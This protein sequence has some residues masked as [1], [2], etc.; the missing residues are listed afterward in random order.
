MYL[1]LFDVDGTL[2]D[3]QNIIFE[4]MRRAFEGEGRPIP[5][6]QAV[7]AII[8]MSLPVALA[9]LS[10]GDP[11]DA[12]TSA[13]VGR[14]KAAFHDLRLM[15]THYEALFPGAR[16]TLLAL[17]RRPDVILGIATGKSRRGV[18]AVIDTYGFDGL[19]ATIQTADTHPSKPHPSMIVTALAEVGVTPDKAVMVGDSSFDMEMARAA[20]VHA[21]AV[22]WGYQ[23]VAALEASGAHAVVDAFDEVE[24]ALA[25]LLNW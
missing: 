14:Y 16:E 1:V 8:G 12:L 9:E 24:P 4:G 22:G 15:A 7:L 5:T 21:L 18:T 11:D 6:R 25:R 19:F 3:S 13:L 17:K 23:S 20:G 2:V 10:G